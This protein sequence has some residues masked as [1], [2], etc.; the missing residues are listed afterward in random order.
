[1]RKNSYCERTV[2]V[3]DKVTV[4]QSNSNLKLKVVTIMKCAHTSHHPVR[5]EGVGGGGVAGRVGGGEAQLVGRGGH[6]VPHRVLSLLPWQAST[7]CGSRE[8]T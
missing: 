8:G 1:M 6:Q 2:N 7:H 5:G 4:N 3:S